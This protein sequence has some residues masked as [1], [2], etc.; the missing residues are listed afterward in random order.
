MSIDC[1][2]CE[3]GIKLRNKEGDGELNKKSRFY[4]LISYLI[5][6][7]FTFQCSIGIYADNLTMNTGDKGNSSIKKEKKIP[8]LNV[9][10]AKKPHKIPYGLSKKADAFEKWKN[11]KE[12]VE[13]RTENSKT[14]LNEDGTKTAVVFMQPIHVKDSKGNYVDVDSSL[15]ETKGRGGKYSYKNKTG[16][17]DVFF[18]GSKN[19]EASY[20]VEKDNISVEI[21]PE[22]LIN[23]DMVVEDN[24]VFYP[25]DKAGVDCLY[26]VYDLGV[27]ED[28]IVSSYRENLEFTYK[29][30][31]NGPAEVIQEDGTILINDKKTGENVFALSAPYMEDAQGNLS[32]SIELKLEQKAGKYIITLT[33]DD[34]WL[35]ASERAYP[36]K[37]DPS[38]TYVERK[39]ELSPSE[40][41]DNFVQEIKPRY[42]HC[43]EFM[44][45]VGYDDGIASQNMK[46]YNNYKGKTR[47]YMGFKLPTD[48]TKEGVIVNSATLSLYKYTKW[49]G[50]RREVQLYKIDSSVNINNITYGSQPPSSGP[51]TSTTITDDVKEYEWDIQSLVQQWT[52]GNNYGIMLRLENEGDQAD[53]FY[54]TNHATN[55]PKVV[56]NYG[57]HRYA[58]YTAAITFSRRPGACA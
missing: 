28:I 45:Y 10:K 44:I 14:Y 21:S 7:I 8:E 32:N 42:P 34:E 31:V 55:K 1:N 6:I 39:A 33:P 53:C 27:K 43:T 48:L 50:S 49:T 13:N 23:E 52:K 25:T 15:V 11:K 16:M 2:I 5:I 40:I 47:G 4:K 35:K 37:I 56:I 12:L 17:F 41:S 29:M 19:G 22:G 51:V 30:D 20:K 36:V 54:S 46:L 24:R 18:T 26:T 3:C 9:A 38:T 57:I 58:C